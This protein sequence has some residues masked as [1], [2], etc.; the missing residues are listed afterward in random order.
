MS[1]CQQTLE[2]L[3]ERGERAR[4]SGSTRAIRE[5]FKAESSLYWRQTV[6]EREA[7]FAQLR[8]AEAY[9]AVRLEWARLGGADRHLEAIVLQDVD[10]LAG[11]LGR[12]TAADKVAAARVRLEPWCGA[13]PAIQRVLD[14]WAAGRKVR[15]LGPDAAREF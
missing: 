14:A 1:L 6:P 4:V 5:S 3:L 7:M 8:R 9:G 15:S 13:V 10:A 2:Q 12:S 11:H